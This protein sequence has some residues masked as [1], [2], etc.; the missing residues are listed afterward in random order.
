MQLQQYTK[1]GT[2]VEE[3]IMLTI[4]RRI[5]K[6]CLLISSV[7]VRPKETRELEH[8]TTGSIIDLYV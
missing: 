5:L 2:L 6:E 4:K 1:K 7:Q 3:V 8:G